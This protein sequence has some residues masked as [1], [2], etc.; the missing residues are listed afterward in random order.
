MMT[1]SEKMRLG[2]ALMSEACVEADDEDGHSSP[3]DTCPAT[4]YC[5]VLHEVGEARNLPPIYNWDEFDYEG[6]PTK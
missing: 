1:W 4:R 3:C 6:N 2:M 5:E